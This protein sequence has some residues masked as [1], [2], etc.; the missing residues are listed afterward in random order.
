MACS[1][2]PEEFLEVLRPLLPADKPVGPRGGRPP[3]PNVVAMSVIWYVLSTGIR[4][5][6]V[7][8]EMGCSG[9]TA[10]RRLQCWQEASLW[11]A[12][13]MKLLA[14]LNRDGK[15]DLD[16]GIVDSTMVPAPGGGAATGPN[17]TDRSKTGTK[18][19]LLV[20]GNGTPLA[21]I[22]TGANASDQKQL[23]PIINKFPRV[24]GK[25]GRPKEHPNVAL[26]D[27]GY[28]SEANRLLLRWL[29]IEPFIAQRR[30]EHGSGLGIFRWVVE[31]TNGWLKGLKRMR[32][33]WDRLPAIQHAWNALAMCIICFRL[34]AECCQ[35]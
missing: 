32:I 11:D 34:W 13:H 2:I 8:P 24:K 15:L 10:H 1:V 33:R 7:L 6:D 17:P 30:T 27:R 18:H 28:D 4:W 23:E 9:R 25:P 29:G 5:Q 19:T 12:L 31:R 16:M 26:A 20:D 21:L 22:T 3:V 14:L 35:C